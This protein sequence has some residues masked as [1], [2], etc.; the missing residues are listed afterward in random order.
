MQIQVHEIYFA[1]NKYIIWSGNCF[2]WHN[3]KR[4]E[5]ITH[6]IQKFS[7]AFNEVRAW[8]VVIIETCDNENWSQIEGRIL[9]DY[10]E[11]VD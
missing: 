11:E 5:F 7:I 4:L 3:N 2:R 8:V 6:D 9:V 10:I 1:V